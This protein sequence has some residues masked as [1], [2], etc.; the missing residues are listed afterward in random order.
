VS[1][2]IHAGPFADN[3]GQWGA[4]RGAKLWVGSTRATA[5]P[6]G[7]VIR[8]TRPGVRTVVQRRPPEAIAFVDDLAVFYPGV[9][10]LPGGGS[11]RLHVRIGPDR[12]CFLVSS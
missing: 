10:R 7:A 5:R 4:I 8:A 11:W 3:R 6:T 2:V 1:G 9:I 12:G